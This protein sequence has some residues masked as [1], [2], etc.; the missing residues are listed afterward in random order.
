MIDLH[1]H[2]TASDGQHSPAELLALAASAGVTV[3]AVTDHDTVAGLG[4]AEEAAR[5]HGIELV[6]GIE[7]SAFVLRREVHILG[8]FVRPDFP[9]LASYAARLRVEREQ[10]M[11]RMVEGLRK[12]GFP[13][14]MEEVRAI[15]G[16]AQ[17]GR[18][19]LARLL[20]ERGWCLDVKD[21][22]DRFLG[23]GKAAWVDRFKLEGAEAIR[24]IHRAGGTATLAH[25]GSSKVER[26]E[27]LQLAKAGLDGMEALHADHNPSVQEKYL[28]FAKE[29]DLVP[30][31]GSDFHG[32]QVTPGK[33]PGDSTTP[34]ANFA[35]LRAR[36]SSQAAHPAS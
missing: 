7:L 2:T 8:H 30:T 3:L 18:P 11:E 32:E 31:G 36:A 22:F 33:R 5:A 28:R 9:E 35:K 20:V 25:P 14:R 4:E 12:M 21:A 15:A 26:Y 27:L 10:R 16:S 19:H 29:F 13:V 6:P 24:L 17:L 34:A 23:A 1:S